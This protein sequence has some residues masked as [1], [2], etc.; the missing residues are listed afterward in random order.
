MTHSCDK[1]CS[2]CLA[3]TLLVA[4]LAGVQAAEIRL[5]SQSEATT[6]VLTLGDVAEIL[7]SDP[8]ETQQL[9]AIELGSAPPP[10]QQRFLRVREI[11]DLLWA[12][13]VNLL[14]HQFSGYGLVAVTRA[15]EQPARTTADKNLSSDATRRASTL[16]QQALGDYLRS[17][18][19]E[20]GKVEVV[21]SDTQVRTVLTAQSPLAVRGGMP[22]WNRQQRFELAFTGPEG[23]V[24]LPLDARLSTATAVVTPVRTL[25]RGAVIRPEDVQ[26][27][28]LTAAPPA[29]R[30]M[31]CSLEEVVGRET[32]RAVQEGKPLE[33]D[34]LRS[35]PLVRRGEMVTVFAQAPGLKV[36][37]MARARDDAGLGEQVVLDSLHER[38]PLLARVVGFQEAEALAA[39]PPQRLDRNTTRSRRTTT[40]VPE[41]TAR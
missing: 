1:F 6:P 31:P 35:Q 4:G 5:R 40:H 15:A 32:T 34:A 11:Q 33:S 30:A 25:P 18:G 10:G 37:T 39:A 28:Q 12:Q 3:I 16:V 23:A 20:V 36:K 29:G 17:R 38:K 7:S 26:L 13:R 2:G 24:T 41:R 21:L 22:P 8:A 14:A 19:V 9:A 27:T